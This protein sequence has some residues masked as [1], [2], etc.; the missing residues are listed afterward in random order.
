MSKEVITLTLDTLDTIYDLIK[1]SD[2][3]KSD[4][5]F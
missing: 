3:K 2:N 1:L 5:I 4:N